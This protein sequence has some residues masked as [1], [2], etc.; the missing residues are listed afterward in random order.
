MDARHISQAMKVS[1]QKLKLQWINRALKAKDAFFGYRRFEWVV[2]IRSKLHS[3]SLEFL[4]DRWRWFRQLIWR[5]F[6][7]LPRELIQRA[8]EG[9]D[10]RLHLERLSLF[11]EEGQLDLVV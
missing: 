11:N 8:L 6:A 10:A 3:R 9:F 1:T 5:L 2:F 7:S 4:G